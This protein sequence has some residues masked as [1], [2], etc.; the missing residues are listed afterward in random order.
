MHARRSSEDLNDLLT[1]AT[2]GLSAC[3]TVTSL[4][5]T[6]TYCA[7]RGQLAGPLAL[8]TAALPEV[9]VSLSV[10]RLRTDAGR[11]SKAWAALYLVT[12]VAFTVRANLGD[13]VTLGGWDRA[14]VAVWPVW[15]T[16]GAAGL[17]DTGR[18]VLPA[19]TSAEALPDAEPAG[20]P[21]EPQTTAETPAE[22]SAD[23]AP[24][25]IPR[26]RRQAP[27]RTPAGG[28]PGTSREER[29]AWLRAEMPAHP[30]R[31]AEEWAEIL[32]C[33]PRTYWRVIEHMREHVPGEERVA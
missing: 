1:R 21:A 24:P 8:L 31:S 32:G 28:P 2:L 27:A 29:A 7:E 5:H 23:D 4:P 20:T 22:D 15:A 14:L 16:I 3:A 13:V 9:S 18:A 11:L 19:E 30:D 26:Q 33:S 6:F 12:S 17:L 25:D 10:L